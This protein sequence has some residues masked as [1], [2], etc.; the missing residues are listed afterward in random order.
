MLG[1]CTTFADPRLDTTSMN[2]INDNFTNL[3][4]SVSRKAKCLSV[5]VTGDYLAADR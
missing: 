2:N 1:K 4:A 5:E 3:N